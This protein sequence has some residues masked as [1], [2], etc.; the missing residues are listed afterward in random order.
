MA[1]AI[2]FGG[3]FLG[4]LVGFIIMALL[5]VA[6]RPSKPKRRWQSR[7]ILSAPTLSPGSLALRWKTGHRPSEPGL[8]LG[9]DRVGGERPGT[10]VWQ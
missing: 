6:S 7:V 9:L 4:F 3:I 8:P 2:F 1:Y 5:A 10:R